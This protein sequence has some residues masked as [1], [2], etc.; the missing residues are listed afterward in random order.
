MLLND[1][2]FLQ[3]VSGTEGAATFHI[4]VKEDHP[5]YKGHFPGQPV[6]P[7]VILAEMVKELLEN[8][9]DKSLEMVRMR[10]C[11][12]LSAHHPAQHARMEISVSWTPGDEYT[13][14]A[15]GSFQPEV[16]F[17]L[18]ACYKEA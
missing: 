13:V 16:F 15:N 17:R 9:L 2:Y 1:L 8:H 7:G 6:T 12:F 10:Q 11:K 14:Q 4:L 3:S 18:S 5:L